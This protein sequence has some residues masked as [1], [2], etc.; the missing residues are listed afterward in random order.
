MAARL[1]WASDTREARWLTCCRAAVFC[2]DGV[3]E[4]TRQREEL[5]EIFAL[6]IPQLP[7]GRVL[8]G[9]PHFTLGDAF[10]DLGC[11]C[12]T[13]LMQTCAQTIAGAK[14]AA[15]NEGAQAP[16]TPFELKQHETFAQNSTTK[17]G[18]HGY[19]YGAR[20]RPTVLFQFV[21]PVLDR[22]GFADPGA[23][24]TAI[25]HWQPRTCGHWQPRTCVGGGAFAL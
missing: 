9:P 16:F 2:A 8:Q 14:K 21:A 18:S 10:D 25:R 22:C 24:E 3:S 1:V 4:F 20:D 13:T 5:V 7:T 15:G 6:G 19:L 23:I 17:R 12:G 11:E